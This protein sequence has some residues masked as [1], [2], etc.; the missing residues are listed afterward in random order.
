MLGSRLLYSCCTL[1]LLVLVSS[2]ADITLLR[3]MP[4]SVSPSSL[5][6]PSAPRTAVSCDASSIHAP[7]VRLSRET[8]E[9]YLRGSDVAVLP[10]PPS[11][12]KFHREYVSANLPVLI[13][14]ALDGWP[15][16]ERWRSNDYLRRAMGEQ[17]VSVACTPHGRADSVQDGALMLPCEERWPFG[18]FMDYIERRKQQGR[19]T[20]ADSGMGGAEAEVC[21]LQAQNA[22]F[23]SEF[24]TLHD[25]VLPLEWASVAF[26]DAPDAVNLWMG[27]SESLTALHQDNYENLYTVITGSKTFL[28]FPP[29]DLYWLHERVYPVG[30][31]VRDPHAAALQA[32]RDEAA[33]AVPWVADV[34]Q[35]LRE[36]EAK[37]RQR[38]CEQGEH[39]EWGE[40]EDEDKEEDEDDSAAA[41]PAKDGS[42]DEDELPSERTITEDMRRQFAKSVITPL[43]A[44]AAAASDH[45]AAQQI[46]SVI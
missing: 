40:G 21:Y 19:A 41:G 13:R 23:S 6:H 37:L 26:N 25:D 10:S 17:V 39:T 24:E 36:M 22:S 29:T 38:D 32:S 27:N 45:S 20:A 3:V 1:L 5:V 15:A 4:S 43:V 31:Y 11:P 8:R 33:S 34:E 14:G 42:D 2:H 30:R 46:S 12:L 9:L 16:L 44:A 18:R 7:F 35:Q 28:L